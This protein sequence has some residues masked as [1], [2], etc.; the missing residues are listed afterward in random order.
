[1]TRQ[2]QLFP[3][4]AAI[5]LFG[6]GAFSQPVTVRQLDTPQA[7]AAPVSGGLTV[8]PEEVVFPDSSSSAW[9]NLQIDG[10]PV[11]AKQISAKIAGSY[12]WM[13]TIEKPE[14]QP[15]FVL[16]RCTPGNTEFG[17]YELIV[18]ASGQE[19]RVRIVVTLANEMAQLTEA[20]RP[21]PR[22]LGASIQL[23]HEYREG[24]V[25]ELDFGP[26]CANCWYSWRLNAEEVLEGV[27]EHKLRYTLVQS[28]PVEISV[29]GKR[30][31]LTVVQWQG[32]TNVQAH[33]VENLQLKP[34]TTLTLRGPAG[35]S[36]YEWR[37]DDANAGNQSQLAHKFERAGLYRV[38]CYARSPEG[39]ASATGY[40][41]HE[42]SV[43]VQ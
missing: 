21:K 23:P 11:P 22:V 2:C 39:T 25:L 24:Q 31:G 33:T 41:R 6:A 43:Q 4:I 40:Y 36:E 34:G 7:A 13:F 5:A 10:K 16:L 15:G 8:T 20:Q 12:G 42:W 38:D 19:R 29:E 35:Y 3:A 17:Q 32:R 14:K 27:G 1:M 26:Y 28:G 30:D 37:I 18:S 9:I